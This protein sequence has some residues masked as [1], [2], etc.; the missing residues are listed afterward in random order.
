MYRAD[1]AVTALLKKAKFGKPVF[2]MGHSRLITN[3][4]ADNQPVYRDSVCLIHNGIIVNHE[5]L[6]EKTQ[7]KRKQEIDTEIIAAIIAE[8][9][10]NGVPV[11]QAHERVLSLCKGIVACA[12]ALP[13]LGKLCLFSNNGSLYLGKKDGAWH[14]ASEEFPLKQLRCSG[15]RQIKDAVILDIPV[16]ADAPEIH[17]TNSRKVNLIPEL[18]T[19]ADEERLLTYFQPN[20]R[21]C[22]KCILPET[23][24]FINFDEHG[25]CNYCRHYKPRNKPRPVEELFKLV[26]SYRRKDGDD[27]IVPFSGGRDSCFGLHLIVNELKMKPITY[28]YDW[29]MVRDPGRRNISSMSAAHD[30]DNIIVAA[31][32]D[33]KRMNNARNLKAW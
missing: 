10:E 24:P 13:K 23:M 16:S 6:W 27:C 32:I 17:E 31:D 22:I 12:V 3:G 29:G 28:T 1:T 4:L 9:I 18:G 2:A 11:E 8:D 33:K 25:V 19:H 5:D 7:K 26:E 30:V 15:I 21:R 20:L 14:F